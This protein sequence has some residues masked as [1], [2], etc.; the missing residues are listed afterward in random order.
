MSKDWNWKGDKNRDTD[1]V[2]AWLVDTIRAERI[3][4]FNL[5]MSIIPDDIFARLG[6]ERTSGGLK[7]NN[8]TIITALM[9]LTEQCIIEKR[10]EEISQGS[11]HDDVP[12]PHRDILHGDMP[13]DNTAEGLAWREKVNRK[14][15]CFAMLVYLER[16][17]R[18]GKV[19]YTA[20]SPWHEGTGSVIVSD[21]QGMFP[22]KALSPKYA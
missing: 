16:L 3:D 2:S 21:Y 11:T 14:I 10:A 7:P 15:N 12:E 6:C 5:D 1:D 8:A 20:V 4:V 17:K 22:D 19:E 9:L 18:Q 13:P